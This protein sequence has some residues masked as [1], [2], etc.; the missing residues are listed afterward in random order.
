LDRLVSDLLLLAR[1]DERGLDLT[2]GD[3]DLDDVVGAEVARLRRTTKLVIDAAVIPVQVPGDRHQLERLLRNLTDNAARHAV[4][5]IRI[6]LRVDAASAVV[7]VVDDGSGIPDEQRERVFDRFVRLD[8]S[9]HRGGGG[10]GLG[11]SIAREIARA[12]GGTLV[13]EPATKG[14]L[15]VL[16]LPRPPS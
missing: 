4:G 1:A 2:W 16:R 3:V 13:A 15:L 8:E 7:E 6:A 14:A 12:H 11:L 9:R 5:R 10:T